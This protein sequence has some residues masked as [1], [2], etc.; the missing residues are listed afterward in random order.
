MKSR[1]LGPAALINE[2]AAARVRP[3]CPGNDTSPTR[4]GFI[5]G[6]IGPES[7]D[8][9]LT[10]SLGRMLG[11]TPPR[12]ETHTTW[13]CLV[14]SCRLRMFARDDCQSAEPND[15]YEVFHSAKPLRPAASSLWVKLVGGTKPSC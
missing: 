14:D 12:M 4:V 13:N 7:P 11:W 10:V 2:Q 8:K 3:T 1:P 9:I 5:E 6:Q 15:A